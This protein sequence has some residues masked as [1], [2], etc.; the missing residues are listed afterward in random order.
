MKVLLGIGGS[1]DSIRALEKTVERTANV[2]DDLTVAIVDNPSVERSRED[3]ETRVTE[4]LDERGVEATVRLL[5]GDAGSA[6]VDLAENEGF[7]Q[8]VLG[9]GETSPM[10]KIQIGS[11]AEFVLLNSHV[12]VTLVR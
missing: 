7:D 9:G 6:L 2:D 8:L 10:G 1:D 11:I 4:L 12:T 5:D 3:I